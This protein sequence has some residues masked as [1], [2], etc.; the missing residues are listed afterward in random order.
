MYYLAESYKKNAINSNFENFER[1]LYMK[2]VSMP[3]IWNFVLSPKDLKTYW[4]IFKMQDGPIKK[5]NMQTNQQSNK[6]YFVFG[7]GSLHYIW[8]PIKKL[9][10]MTRS[11]EWTKLR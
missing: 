9:N 8:V 2:S 11:V 3:L 1:A 4:D 10:K 5:K 7:H 6:A